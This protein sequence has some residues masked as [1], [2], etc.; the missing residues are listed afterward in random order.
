MATAVPV[1]GTGQMFVQVEKDRP[2]DMAG[3]VPSPSRGGVGQI[4][5]TI[6]HDDVVFVET[7][8]QPVHVHDDVPGDMG[9]GCS[10]HRFLSASFSFRTKVRRGPLQRRTCKKM[11]TAVKM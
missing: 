2:R 1:S 3:I 8:R 11:Y 6:R 10:F 9:T 5:S 7:G 4:K